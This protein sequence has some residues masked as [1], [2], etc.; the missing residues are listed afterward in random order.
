MIIR[1]WWVA[2]PTWIVRIFKFLCIVITTY[3]HIIKIC[4]IFNIHQYSVFRDGIWS[5]FD[6]KNDIDSLFLLN[7]LDWREL[8][9]LNGLD[10]I[11]SY[12]V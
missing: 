8:I 12:K 2:W 5:Y 7:G 11:G 9:L 1:I 10:W 6:L 3:T 4:E